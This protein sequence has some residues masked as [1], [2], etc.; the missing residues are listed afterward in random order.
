MLPEYQV[1]H[2]CPFALLLRLSGNS[3]PYTEAT[4]L[5]VAGNGNTYW[6]H[7]NTLL[8]HMQGYNSEYIPAQHTWLLDLPLQV[9]NVEMK[10]AA[11]TIGHRKKAAS[12]TLQLVMHLTCLLLNN[13]GISLATSPTDIIIWFCHLTG[14]MLR[15]QQIC[16]LWAVTPLHFIP[17]FKS[18]CG[19]TLQGP[20]RAVARVSHNAVS[21]WQQPVIYPKRAHMWQAALWKMLI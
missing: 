16:Q 20:C 11:L 10:K 4:W 14:A 21:S 5:C 1:F 8:S 6:M 12:S 18:L 19:D 3:V 7:T 9:Q 17:V 13:F 15:K 2:S